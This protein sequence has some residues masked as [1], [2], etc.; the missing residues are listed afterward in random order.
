MA[1]K[2]EYTIKEKTGDYW[3]ITNI[4]ENY[5]NKD[6]LVVVSLY[7]SR[8]TRD[9]N[10]RSYIHRQLVRINKQY[11]DSSIED[12]RDAVYSDLMNENQDIID[13]N[14]KGFFVGTEIY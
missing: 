9:D 12:L 13:T 5:I 3:R 7:V 4:A 11:P 6:T 14:N 1:I 10:E 8:A 2:K